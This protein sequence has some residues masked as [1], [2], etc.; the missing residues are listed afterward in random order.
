M[1]K[2][3]QA[4]M[5]FDDEKFVLIEDKVRLSKIYMKRTPPKMFSSSGSETLEQA[6][7]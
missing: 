6:S 5:Q 2:L 7:I 4:N 3:Q 1:N